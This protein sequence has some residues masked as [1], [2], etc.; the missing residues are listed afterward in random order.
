MKNYREPRV[1]Y[2]SVAAKCHDGKI[3]T[4]TEE[5]SQIQFRNM[6]SVLVEFEGVL[7]S[8]A[9]NTII[10]WNSTIGNVNYTYSLT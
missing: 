6:P 2:Y 3:I 4:R 5:F 10:R 8:D 1:K 9:R 7:F